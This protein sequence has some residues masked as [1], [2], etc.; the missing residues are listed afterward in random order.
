MLASLFFTLLGE[1]FGKRIKTQITVVSSDYGKLITKGEVARFKEGDLSACKSIFF[2]YFPAGLAAF[3]L[4]VAGLNFLFI[5]SAKLGLITVGSI[6]ISNLGGSNLR[7]SRDRK[8]V[9]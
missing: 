7:D 2:L 9:V 5:R 6:A 4:I 3:L 1:R 8:S